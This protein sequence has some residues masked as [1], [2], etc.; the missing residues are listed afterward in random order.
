[1]STVSSRVVVVTGASRGIG[2][3]MVRGLKSQG[4]RVAAC[5]RSLAALAESPA[6]HRFACD[7]SDVAQVKVGIEG[8]LAALGRIDGVINNAGVAGTNPMD[9]GSSDELW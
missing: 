1:M 3:A 7:V 4:Y 8:T 5:S 2:A 9:P 6:D